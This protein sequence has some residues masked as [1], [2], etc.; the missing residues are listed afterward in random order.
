MKRAERAEGAEG[1]EGMKRT[2]EE[3][4]SCLSPQIAHHSP[5]NNQ[6]PTTTYQLPITLS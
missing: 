2:E 3:N 4:A 6:L 5:P 1:A